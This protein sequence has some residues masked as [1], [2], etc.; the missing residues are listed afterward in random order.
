MEDECDFV[1]LGFFMS[2]TEPMQI[3][4]KYEGLEQGW[5]NFMELVVKIRQ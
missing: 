2:S 4:Y 1:C 5:H 3:Y